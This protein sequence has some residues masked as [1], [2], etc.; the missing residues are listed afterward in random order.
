MDRDLSEAAVACVVT[1]KI[2]RGSD[3]PIECLHVLKMQVRRG[4]FDLEIWPRI[5][6]GC[7]NIVDFLVKSQHPSAQVMFIAE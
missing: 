4:F 3:G 7:L 2:A 6:F 5:V 1:L